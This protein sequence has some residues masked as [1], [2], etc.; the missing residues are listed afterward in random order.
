MSVPDVTVRAAFGSNAMATSPTW[1]DISAWVLKVS[2]SAGRSKNTDTF[3]A[4]TASI[5]LD[6]SDRRFDPTHL[7]GPYVSGGISQLIP[8][9]RIEVTALWSAVTYH[10][11][12]VWA[13]SWTVQHD[14]EM[15]T[16]TVEA[17]DG[18]KFLG[19]VVIPEQGAAHAGDISGARINRVLDLADWPAG[20]RSVDDGITDLPSTVFGESAKDHC[21]KVAYAER[22]AFFFGPNG[23]ARFVGRHDQFTDTNRLTPTETFSDLP[24]HTGP[25]WSTVAPMRI[26]D[27]ELVN[28]V[29]VSRSGGVPQTQET[30]AS[31]TKYGWL[32][33]GAVSDCLVRDDNAAKNVAR[34]YLALND[35]PFV[36]VNEM[37]MDIIDDT[38]DEYEQALKR[39]LRERVRV[40]VLPPGGG[41]RISQD[42]FIEGI[43]HSIQAGSWTTSWTLSSV[44]RY[45]QFGGA[46]SWLLVGNTLNQS[47]VGTGKVAP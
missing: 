6:N 17:T 20:L 41:V 44:A 25:R 26:D 4:G 47:K 38:S 39:Q 19:R 24:A 36:S 45:D 29:T 2:T 22:G 10:L 43:R 37:A 31:V 3:G 27:T 18:V 16:C 30:A 28:S 32:T 12:T 15:S 9:V 23:H 5:T 40:D 8:N 35:E 34:F 1:T 42:S 7:T 33:G 11:A 21:D 46:T 14:T 13:D